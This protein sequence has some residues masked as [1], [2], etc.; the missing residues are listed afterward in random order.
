MPGK[1][2]KSPARHIEVADGSL[3]EAKEHG[4]VSGI[5]KTRNGE[6]NATLRN[7]LYVPSLCLNINLTSASAIQENGYAVLFSQNSCEILQK[8]DSAVALSVPRTGRSYK[9]T[10]MVRESA[11]SA[12]E[13][14]FRMWHARLGHPALTILEELHSRA[15]LPVKCSNEEM[16]PNDSTACL[17][18]KMQRRSFKEPTEWK[19]RQKLELTQ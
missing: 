19:K 12:K 13:V 8:S 1:L 6:Y 16:E 3:M 11:C 18:G 9:V 5:F 7:F 15:L 14:S 2:C 17:K 4:N 10:Y